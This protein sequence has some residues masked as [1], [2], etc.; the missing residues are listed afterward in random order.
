M[1]LAGQRREAH[2]RELGR[3]IA[4]KVA[5]HLA[6]AARHQHV[7]HRL[8]NPSPARDS[9]EMR[10]RPEQPSSNNPY[11]HSVNKLCRL[12]D[13][14]GIV[15]E[16]LVRIRGI[17]VG[18]LWVSCWILGLPALAPKGKIAIFAGS[19]YGGHLITVGCDPNGF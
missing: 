12:A 5:R 10:L 9:Q 19:A 7:G 13:Y 8:R 1:R 11:S 6:I 2:V 17:P 4:R 14:A 16:G 3:A 18:F 15:N